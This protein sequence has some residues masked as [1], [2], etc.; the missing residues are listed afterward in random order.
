MSC[1]YN[2]CFSL[3][4][5]LNLELS[6]NFFHS[7]DTG[8]A[9]PLPASDDDKYFYELILTK[10]I[11]KSSK[12]LKA[13]K[14]TK[15]VLFPSRILPCKHSCVQYTTLYT[16]NTHRLRRRDQSY[17]KRHRL[18]CKSGDQEVPLQRR[19]SAQRWAQCFASIQ[20]SFSC[21]NSLLG[22]SLDSYKC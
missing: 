7:I 9:K 5:L 12:S 1:D 8:T 15:L 11:K 18:V 3:R 13:L 21:T 19:L 22:F 2:L 17:S 4:N 14:N 20:P 16:I 6:V 10:Q